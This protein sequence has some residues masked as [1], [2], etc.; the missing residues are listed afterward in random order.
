[1]IYAELWDGGCINRGQSLIVWWHGWLWREI[2]NLKYPYWETIGRT[3]SAIVRYI[4]LLLSHHTLL[5]SPSARWDIKDTWQSVPSKINPTVRKKMITWLLLIT[6]NGI[7][8]LER[9]D[10]HKS[11]FWSHLYHVV[12]WPNVD[13]YFFYE[14]T[15]TLILSLSLSLVLM[16]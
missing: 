15:I 1:M 12:S 6:A 9:K 11:S 5:L 14:K 7:N 13:H 8:F 16:S 4:V 3:T 10:F 2:E